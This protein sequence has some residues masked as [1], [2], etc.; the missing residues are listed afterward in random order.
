MDRTIIVVFL[1][2]FPFVVLGAFVF[3]VAKFPQNLFGP[4]DFKDPNDWARMMQAATTLAATAASKPS[5][6]QAPSPSAIATQSVQAVRNVSQRS[7]SQDPT[8]TKHLL[9]VDD[10]PENNAGLQRTFKTL[11]VDVTNALSTEQ[12]LELS[13][14]ARF[15]AI[16]SDMGRGTDREAGH[17]LLKALRASGDKTPYF[18]FSSRANSARLAETKKLGGTG[19]TSSAP[20]LLE[21]VGAVLGS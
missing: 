21:Q 14:V 11:N 7:W 16:I 5:E 13:K 1:A 6:G 8:R 20:E 4:G 9:W 18:I 17:T 19:N 15:D 10:H 2:T 12:A 3:L